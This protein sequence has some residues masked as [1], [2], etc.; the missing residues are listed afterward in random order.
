MQGF[1]LSS[2]KKAIA[3]AA[4]VIALAFYAGCSDSEATS[5]S[6]DN[7]PN[8][9][10]GVRVSLPHEGSSGLGKASTITLNKLILVLTSN[11]GDTIRDTV[12]GSTTPALS[13][14]VLADQTV[15]KYYAIKPLRTWKL[16]GKTLD[17]N[18]FVI[19]FDSV[20]VSTPILAGDTGLIPLS[21]NAKYVMYQANFLLPD[22]IGSS[23]TSNHVKQKI[24]FD[25][26]V[27]QVNGVNVRDSS[28]TY[29][30]VAPNPATL[31]YDYVPV[32]SDTVKMLAYGNLGSGPS[33]LL[34]KDST[35]INPV[36][37]TT[38]T[39][40]LVYVGPNGNSATGH[41]SVTIGKVITV[42]LTG[43]PDPNPFPKTSARP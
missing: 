23:D 36:H 41:A 12:T 6:A 3:L 4:A 10:L 19:H 39:R 32:G 43:N 18:N 22:S 9:A 20:T 1:K 35:V 28:K 25:R 29:F 5:P 14:S 42:T 17:A 27:L 37:D 8:A 26:L 13:S 33:I 15:S 40:T 38:A 24:N 16:I 34:Y 7:V 30:P 31:N 2:M 21:M 11:K